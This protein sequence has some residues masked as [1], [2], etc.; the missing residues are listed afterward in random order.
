MNF[1]V[2]LALVGIGA[3]SV[4]GTN[5]REVTATVG[6]SVSLDFD[7][8]GPTNVRFNFLKDRRY[9][10]ADRRRI[11]QRLGRI[12]ISKVAESDSGAY[13]MIVRG[14][15]VYYNKGIILKG[16]NL[17][18]YYC[19]LMYFICIFVFMYLLVFCMYFMFY[20]IFYYLQC[21]LMMTIQ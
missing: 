4:T 8:N 12:Y 11:F 10:K 16:K 21:Y 19:N 15:R 1:I 14:N 13:Q 18:Y 20:S 2:L 17:V 5:T 9:F 3:V 6:E 7:Y